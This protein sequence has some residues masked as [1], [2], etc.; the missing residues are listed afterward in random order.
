[1]LSIDLLAYYR[2]VSQQKLTVVDVETTGHFTPEH[3]VIELSVLQ[4]TLEDGI[5]IHQTNLIDPQTK[6]PPKISRITGITQDMVDA[7]QPAAEV[8]PDYWQLLNS[9]I[10][11]AHN[12]EFDYSFLQLEYSRLNTLFS[13]P[14]NQQLC[15][16]Q[17]ARQMLPEL[18]SRSLPD[19]VRHFQFQ[20]GTS[21]R[22]EADTLACWLLAKR[23]LTE[24][25]NEDDAILLARFAKQWL[26]LQYAA[27]ILGCSQQEGRSRLE[28]ADVQSRYVGRGR[29]GTFMYRR[30]DVEQLVHD[31][32]DN[33]QLSLFSEGS[34]SVF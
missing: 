19:L 30:G 21:H 5:Q 2:Q 32:Q 24:I 31:Q 29:S 3:Q 25:L 7:A 20:V 8:L 4:A 9:G 12:L 15:T 27:K 23:L 10:L 11:T 13:R 6:I 22:A 1:M 33:T 34:T 16:V 14:P 17:L 18:R 28:A 26:P